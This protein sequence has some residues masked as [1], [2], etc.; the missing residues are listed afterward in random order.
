MRFVFARHTLGALATQPQVW[1][2][3]TARVVTAEDSTSSKDLR[4]V[5]F[6][7]T[8][9]LWLHALKDHGNRATLLS[10]RRKCGRSILSSTHLYA[11]FSAIKKFSSCNIFSVQ[12]SYLEDAR[13]FWQ[14]ACHFCDGAC[15]SH[16][17]FLQQQHQQQ[18][19]HCSCSSPGVFP[20]YLPR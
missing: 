15:F 17:H 8:T 5:R 10:L 3:E 14:E 12:S 2:F 18:D 6:F 9:H 19:C 20:S 4:Q 1:K 7:L 16:A 13:L 11:A